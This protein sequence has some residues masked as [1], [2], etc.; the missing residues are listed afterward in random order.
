[1]MNSTGVVAI[2]LFAETSSKATLRLEL[3]WHSSGTRTATTE[4]T[5]L[6]T[7]SA[8][9][10]THRWLLIKLASESRIRSGTMISTLMAAAEQTSH[11]LRKIASLNQRPN[12]QSIDLSND[13]IIIFYNIINI[14]NLQEIK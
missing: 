1:M 13:S 4:G 10:N 12:L 11:T 3:T 8:T 7:W 14:L 5:K 2:L 9:L 6:H